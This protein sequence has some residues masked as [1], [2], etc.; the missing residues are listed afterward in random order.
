MLKWK[1][2]AHDKGTLDSAS[3]LFY[4]AFVEGHTVNYD[5]LDW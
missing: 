5:I 3:T 4:K 1:Q 2:P